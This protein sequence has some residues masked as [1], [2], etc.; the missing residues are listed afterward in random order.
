MLNR[1]G[2]RIN[3]FP[4]KLRNYSVLLKFFKMSK[5]YYLAYEKNHELMGALKYHKRLKKS[6]TLSSEDQF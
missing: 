3:K 6:N 1:I 2:H 4:P 5:T